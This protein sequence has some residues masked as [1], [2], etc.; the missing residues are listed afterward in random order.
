[1]RDCDERSFLSAFAP[2]YHCCAAME[3]AIRLLDAPQNT[4]GR[5]NIGA[6]EAPEKTES[7]G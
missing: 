6:T 7:V 1:M 5:G 2:D 3:S 4:L